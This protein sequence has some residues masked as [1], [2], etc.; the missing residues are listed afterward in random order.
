[1]SSL[2]T[3]KL[4]TLDNGSNPQGTS[5]AGLEADLDT[6]VS[7]AFNASVSVLTYSRQYT[8]GIATSVPVYFLSVGQPTDSLGGLLDTIN[9][10]SAKTP[11]SNVVTTS[12]SYNENSISLALATKLCNA[13]AAAGSKGVSL[14]FSSGDGGVTGTKPGNCTTT[15]VPTFPDGCP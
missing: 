14:L 7:L 4:E 11:I 10:I 8:I 1:M 15:F 3:F 2:T 12:Y 13:Y 6:Q 9:F 5:D